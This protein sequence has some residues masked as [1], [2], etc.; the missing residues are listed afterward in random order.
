M[1]PIPHPGN[2]TGHY[3]LL[4][5]AIYLTLIL[6]LIAPDIFPKGPGSRE[7]RRFPAPGAGKFS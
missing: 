1:P 2:L 6:A 4:V 5:E 3:W 7:A